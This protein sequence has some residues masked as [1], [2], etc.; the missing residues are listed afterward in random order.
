MLEL[1]TRERI[2]LL[3]LQS[4]Q[5]APLILFEVWRC[6]FLFCSKGFKRFPASV[7]DKN[8]LYILCN[9]VEWI[10]TSIIN[11]FLCACIWPWPCDSKMSPQACHQRQPNS[12]G[13]WFWPDSD[14]PASVHCSR[15]L[16]T[17]RAPGK[18]MWIAPSMLVYTH[19]TNQLVNLNLKLLSQFVR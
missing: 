12:Q 9:G 15:L 2:Y 10:C 8:Q 1:F 4:T 5:L 6:P 3:D 11:C 19:D 7:K 14:L 18:D 17:S 13:S 16:M